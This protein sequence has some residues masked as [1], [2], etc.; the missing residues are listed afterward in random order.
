MN[1][2][3]ETI[4]QK[5][6]IEMY[7]THNNGKSVIAERFLRTLKNKIHKYM[8]SVSKK[9]YI[10]KLDDIVN[11]HNNTYHTTSK[12]TPDDL[13]SNTFIDSSKKVNG[14]NLKFKIC[15]NFRMSKYK[16]AFAKFTLQ[17]GLNKF[18]W[19]KKLKILYRRHISL[20]ILMEKN[21]LKYFAK[22]NCKKQIKINLQL[23][24]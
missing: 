24:K 18:F 6:D 7:S 8:T 4:I 23:K 12:A 21:L 2:T 5:N 10:D 16:I 11:K 13:R 15:D 22:T 20:M 1:V 14:K 17:I 19:L 9:V 3:K